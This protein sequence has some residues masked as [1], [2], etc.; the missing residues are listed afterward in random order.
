MAQATVMPVG[1][2]GRMALSDLHQFPVWCLKLV[3]L[4]QNCRF[5]VHVED[6]PMSLEMLCMDEEHM[7]TDD[8]ICQPGASGVHLY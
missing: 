4:Q 5:I 1:T 7:K 3:V 6:F 2:A 8:S